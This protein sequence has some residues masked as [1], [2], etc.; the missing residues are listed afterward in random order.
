LFTIDYLFSNLESFFA[1]EIFLKELDGYNDIHYVWDILKRIQEGYIKKILIPEINGILEEGAFVGN[2]VYIGEGTIVETG[3]L[4]KGPTIIGKNCHIRQGAYIRGNVIIGDNCIAGHATE[5]VRAI[6]LPGAK[7][8]HFNYVGDS[9]LGTG[10]NLGAG[11]KL[12]N[13][14]NT[15]SGVVIKYNDNIYETGLKKFGAILGDGC[16]T[17]C[18]AVL[19]PGTIM[20]PDCIVYATTSVRG[21]Y[22]AKTI[23]KLR[24]KIETDELR[25]K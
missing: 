5:V 8:P 24:T 18:N 21:V 16:Q 6:F 14:K 23:I 12:S 25:E 3:A 11:T 4:I 2:D 13:L 7:A 15:K 19:N 20:G 22:P 10:V 17:G 1:K 9:I